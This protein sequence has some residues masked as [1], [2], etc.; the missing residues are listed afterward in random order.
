[1]RVRLN[2][3]FT[4]LTEPRVQHAFTGT[5]RYAPASRALLTVDRPDRSRAVDVWPVPTVKMADIVSL[6]PVSGASL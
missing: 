3:L 2:V 5:V 1:M 6:S 4:G